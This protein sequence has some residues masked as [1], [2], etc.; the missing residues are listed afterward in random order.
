MFALASQPS[1]EPAVPDPSGGAATGGGSPVSS[2]VDPEQV[3][4]VVPSG[5]T[6]DDWLQA[7]L[8]V[9]GAI[10]AAMILRRLVERAAEKSGLEPGVG[11]VAGRAVA[12]IAGAAGII[13]GLNAVGVR[14]GPLLGLFGVGGVALAFALQDILENLIAGVMLQ[15]RRPFAIGDQVQTNEL[16]GVVID[17]DFRSV[18]LKTFDGV[19]VILPSSQVLKN[20]IENRTSFRV[21]R[22]TL[23]VGVGY[24]EDLEHA[25]GLVMEAVASVEGV[26]E[27]PEPEVYIEAFG[28]SSIDLAVRFWHLPDEATMWRVR[29][30]AAIAVKSALDT[31]GVEMPF[32]HRTL[33][34]AWADDRDR[35]GPERPRRRRPVPTGPGRQNGDS[36]GRSARIA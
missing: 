30:A 5:L 35:P 13:Y 9:V 19:R 22:T 20:P 36:G 33:Q 16:E 26:L 32:P 25:T 15:A 28:E 6:W 17:V 12:T 2:E 8:I 18:V 1:P 21:R 31:A 29:H 10:A 3:E 27:S 23:A 7:G 4:S 11:R 14:I 24:D 34:L